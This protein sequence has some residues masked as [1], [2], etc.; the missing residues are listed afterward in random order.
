MIHIMD[1][2]RP[3]H[4]STLTYFKYYTHILQVLY[5]HTSSTILTYFKYHTHILQVLYSHT[6]STILT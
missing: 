3:S 6:S 2:K 4:T 1:R 5:L